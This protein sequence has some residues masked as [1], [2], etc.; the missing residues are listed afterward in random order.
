MLSAYDFFWLFLTVVTVNFLILPF[1]STSYRSQLRLF[2]SPSIYFLMQ[3]EST[4]SSTGLN[5]S[6][7]LPWVRDESSPSLHLSP[8]PPFGRTDAGFS[9]GWYMCTAG[10]DSPTVGNTEQE[11]Q[12]ICG[13]AGWVDHYISCITY[14]KRYCNDTIAKKPILVIIL[15][16][17][18]LKH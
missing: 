5:S 8:P 3:W 1:K 16:R 10:T 9:E 7:S 17:K 14:T 13:R 4:R 6:I 2:F 18:G 11:I 12:L 15:T